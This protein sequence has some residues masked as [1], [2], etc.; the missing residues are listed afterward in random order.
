MT[1]AYS[2]IWRSGS[3]LYYLWGNADWPNFKAT[4]ESRVWGSSPAMTRAQNLSKL[5][6]KQPMR[7]PFPRTETAED[8]YS[9][10]FKGQMI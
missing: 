10:S 5:K 1:F 6:F 3:D 7:N 9:A 2:G 8:G 4:W